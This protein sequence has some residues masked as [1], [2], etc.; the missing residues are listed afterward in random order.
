MISGLIESVEASIESSVSSVDGV[1]GTD[2]KQALSAESLASMGDIIAIPLGYDLDLYLNENSNYA[3]HE[4]IRL[5]VDHQPNYLDPFAEQTVDDTEDFFMEIENICTL[6]STG[7]P[8]LPPS[9]TT[10]WV[11]TLNIW[12]VRVSG[13]YAE[14][15]V[16]DCNQETVFHPLIGHVPLVYCREDAPV[17]DETGTLIGYN[18]PLSFSLDFVACSIVPSWGMM[19]GDI[20][21]GLIESNG[22]S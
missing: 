9:P 19:T 10:P 14:F 17:Y 11:I 13:H 18:R 4:T 15:K 7:L 8:L 6:G 12:I 22:G 1:S 5:A 20:E 3:Y 2:L 16:T 21:G